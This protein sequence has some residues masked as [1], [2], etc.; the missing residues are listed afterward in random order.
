MNE[1]KAFLNSLSAQG[2]NIAELKPYNMKVEHIKENVILYMKNYK[3]NKIV[4][5]NTR[6]RALRS[7]FNFLYK[8]KCL[9]QNRSAEL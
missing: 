2:I 1:F 8:H 7:F 4:S 5:I 6:L 3:G 9:L